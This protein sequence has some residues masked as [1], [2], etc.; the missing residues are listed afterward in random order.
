MA[1]M[2]ARMLV[3]SGCYDGG[4][5]VVA[6]RFWLNSEPFDCGNT[7][8]AVLRG[9]PNPA[10]QANGALMRVSPLAIFGVRLR[11]DEVAELARQ[12]AALTHPNP[13]CQQVNALYVMA[14]T[15]VIK[16]PQLNRKQLYCQICEW[17]RKQDIDPLLHK[18][19]LEA[20]FKRPEDYVTQQGWVIIAWQNALWQLLH[21]ESFEMALIDTVMQGGDTDTN[22]AI[23]GALLGALYGVNEIP[24][25][26][27]N[28][29][30]SCRPQEGDPRVLRPR[31]E[32][33][34]PIDAMELALQ[35]LRI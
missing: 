31:P 24:A 30:L 34:W 6:Y 5:V 1:L 29:V 10:S 23:C 12:D 22:A 33:F 20:F 2:L 7:I 11:L 8:A 3:K 27:R 25:R 21:A 14:L 4:A 28:A 18:A 13:L 35:L 17:V 16:Y 15:E 19:T 9:K 32:C 26:W